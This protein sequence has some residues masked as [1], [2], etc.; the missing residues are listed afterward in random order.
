M[1]WNELTD[2]QL[3]VQERDTEGGIQRKLPEAWAVNWEE[4]NLLI[5]EFIRQNDRCKQSLHETDT[6]KTAR[7][8]PLGDQLA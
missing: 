4:Q 3:E 8:T 7:Y 1:A 6:L 5:M 2:V